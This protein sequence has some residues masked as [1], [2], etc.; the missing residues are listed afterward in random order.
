MCDEPVTEIAAT[1]DATALA[2]VRR[3]CRVS[4]G[5]AGPFALRTVTPEVGE[6]LMRLRAIG[7]GPCFDKAP[8]QAMH[9]SKLRGVESAYR[10]ETS[11]PHHPSLSRRVC[12]DF[13][14]HLWGPCMG[15]RL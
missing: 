2:R 12:V 10:R 14:P 6:H 13:A 11:R 9:R 15:E 1:A 5:T 7:V 3:C 4:S 8:T